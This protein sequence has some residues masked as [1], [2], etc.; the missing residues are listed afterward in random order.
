MDTDGIKTESRKMADQEP[1]KENVFCLNFLL[2]LKFIFFFN[3]I[4]K[5]VGLKMLSKDVGRTESS[6]KEKVF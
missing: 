5:A 2:H 3:L 6:H 4:F 1:I